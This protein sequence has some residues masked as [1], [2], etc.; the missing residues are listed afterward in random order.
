MKA[1]SSESATE[2][3][4]HTSVELIGERPK[5][6]MEWLD[7]DPDKDYYMACGVTPD[8]FDRVCADVKRKGMKA[9]EGPARMRGI[10]PEADLHQVF[11]MSKKLGDKHRDSR[12]KADIGRMEKVSRGL[13]ERKRPGGQDVIRLSDGQI[14]AQR[15]RTKVSHSGGRKRKSISVPGGVISKS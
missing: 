10:S 15:N 1:E 4:E 2:Q 12:R 7:T 3:K 14:I 6:P 11:E 9:H 5:S 13:A 8:G